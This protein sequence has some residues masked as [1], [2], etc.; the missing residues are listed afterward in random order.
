MPRH[1]EELIELISMVG[2]D[3][4][5]SFDGQF[6]R[7]VVAESHIN[8]SCV[9]MSPT[10]DKLSEVTVISDE[11][12]CIGV[13]E[14]E[15]FNIW[16][17]WR[18]LATDSDRIVAKTLKMRNQASIAALIEQKPHVPSDDALVTNWRSGRRPVSLA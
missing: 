5:Q 4:F 1:H 13:S 2:E 15:H 6:E 11:D 14:T 9:R 3:V 10:E 18:M 12:A 8:D 16:Q 7:H 17:P